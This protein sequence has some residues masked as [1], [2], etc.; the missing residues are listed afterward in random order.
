MVF[1]FKKK[2]FNLFSS[3]KILKIDFL[4]VNNSTNIKYQ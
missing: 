4:H 1:N 2:N 3:G